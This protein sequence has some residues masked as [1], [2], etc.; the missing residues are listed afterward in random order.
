[1]TNQYPIC[2][3]DLIVKMCKCEQHEELFKYYKKINFADAVYQE[4]KRNKKL[5]SKKSIDLIGSFEKAFSAIEDKRELGQAYIINLFDQNDDVKKIINKHLR[6]EN[7]IYDDSNNK[8]ILKENIGEKV[9]IIYA[10]VLGIA[11]ILSDDNGSKEFANKFMR[12][13]VIRLNDV[14]RNLG[15][16]NDEIN[17]YNFIANHKYSKQAYD[18]LQ[19]YEANGKLDNFVDIGILNEYRIRYKKE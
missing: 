17:K 2:D 11:V 15:L 6:L 14:L 18:V 7:I 1:M 4:V 12:L 5:S 19:K 16:S 8:Y 9:S 13:N 3:T 10:S